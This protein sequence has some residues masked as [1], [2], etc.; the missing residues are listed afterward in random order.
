MSSARSLQSL[1]AGVAVAFA[2]TT[3]C[4]AQTS[5]TETLSRRYG[6]IRQE[7]DRLKAMTKPWLMRRTARYP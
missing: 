6:R 5:R 7:I 3:A 2:L 1:L 4:D